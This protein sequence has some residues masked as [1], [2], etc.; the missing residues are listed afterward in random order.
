MADVRLQR[1]VSIRGYS[2]IATCFLF[3]SPQA[4]NRL[5]LSIIGI[6]DAV[7]APYCPD[8]ISSVQNMLLRYTRYRSLYLVFLGVCNGP[9]KYRVFVVMSV[10]R[11]I[12]DYLRA[13][14][15]SASCRLNTMVIQELVHTLLVAV[16]IAAT[17][18]LWQFVRS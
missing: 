5:L 10:A 14:L 9:Y 11:N 3:P 6:W 2:E 12:N 7:Y 8:T 17:P 1:A 15:P 18:F 13:A 4:L 16:A